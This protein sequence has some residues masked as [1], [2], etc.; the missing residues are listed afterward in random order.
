M[1]KTHRGLIST[2]GGGFQP[3][4][5]TDPELSEP[6]LSRFSLASILQ[7]IEHEIFWKHQ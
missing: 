6:G 2:N 5:K 4:K 3:T 1:E 7:L